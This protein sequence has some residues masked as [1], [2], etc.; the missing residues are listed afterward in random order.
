MKG[1]SPPQRPVALVLRHSP[2]AGRRAPGH[3][4]GDLIVT[5]V[6]D[7]PALSAG[8]VHAVDSAAETGTPLRIVRAWPVG[9]N[10]RVEVEAE[11]LGDALAFCRR[12]HPGVAVTGRLVQ[13]WPAEV[14]PRES[15]DASLVVLSVAGAQPGGST[16]LGPVGR[17]VL[18][19]ARC[20]VALAWFPDT[21]PE[22]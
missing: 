9:Q 6:G 21:T 8:L 14:L 7:F 3:R 16:V 17:S 4:T 1:D 22:D 11:I 2:P 18:Q 15:A 20:P 12:R 5:G 19:Q 13:G 10:R